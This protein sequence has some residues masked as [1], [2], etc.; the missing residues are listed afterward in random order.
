MEETMPKL[1]ILRAAIPLVLFAFLATLF[2]GHVV[3]AEYG[4]TKTQGEIKSFFTG[5]GSYFEATHE[6]YKDTEGR[7]IYCIQCSAPGPGDGTVTGYT[8]NTAR[9][10]ANPDVVRILRGIA[11]KGYPNQYKTVIVG[12]TAASPQYASGL[13]IRD[14]FLPM[15]QAEAQAATSFAIHSRM[16]ELA[17]AD[18]PGTEGN[19]Y[20]MENVSNASGKDLLSVAMRLKD[21]TACENR[22]DIAWVKKTESGYEETSGIVPSYERD[23]IMRAYARITSFNC[24][25]QSVRLLTGSGYVSGASI[26]DTVYTS[27]FERYVAIDIPMTEANYKLSVALA[28]TAD[29]TV[30]GSARILGHTYYQDM[31]S[32]AR[33]EQMEVRAEGNFAKG[34]AGVYKQDAESKNPI[35]GTSFVVYRNA[36]CTDKAGEMTTDTSG[37]ASLGNL[38]PGVYYVKEISAKAGYITDTAVHR[39]EVRPGTSS[40]FTAS[41]RR[42][43]VTISVTKV[44][45]ETGKA[46]PQGDAE[47]AGAVYGLYADEDIKS[48]DA[49]G[50][51]LFKKD[52][53]V[54]SLT[55][56]DDGTATASGLYPGRYYLKEMKAPKGYLADTEKHIVDCSV[57]SAAVSEVKRAI[58]L[59][60]KPVKAPFALYKF[61]GREGEEQKPLAGAGF[62]A[63]LVSDLTKDADGN[64][65]TEGVRPVALT[66]AGGTEL[67]TD[68]SGYALSRELPYGTYLVRE[69][70][71][72]QGMLSVLDFTVTVDAD[73]RTP[74]RLRMLSDKEVRAR[75]RLYK[76]DS[77]SGERVL[78]P[79][80]GY[81]IF[82]VQQ[83]AY[84]KQQVVYPKRETV[85]VFYTDGEGVLTLPEELPA[86]IYEIEEVE[87]PEDSEYAIAKDR[88]R[89]S[90]TSQTVLPEH[91]GYAYA[92]VR[93]PNDRVYGSIELT[94]TFE[95]GAVYATPTDATMA[96]PLDASV[97]SPTDAATDSFAEF[98]LR[99]ACDIL[100]NGTRLYAEGEKV[101]S[102]KLSKGGT[103]KFEMLPIGRYTLYETKT[104]PGYE[105]MEEP[106]TVEI[107]A[108][109]HKE[110]RPVCRVNVSNQRTRLS[111][112]KVDARN[113]LPI[114]GAE[115]ILTD[116]FGREIDRWTSETGPHEVRGLCSGVT[117]TL[118]ETHAP[119][120][121]LITKKKEFKLSDLGKDATGAYK[122]IMR[123][124]VPVGRITV[125]KKGEVLAEARTRYASGR[126]E[127]MDLR[128]EEQ[129]LA[130]V[131]FALYAGEDLYDGGRVPR[132]RKGEEVAR[133]LTDDGGIACF[134]GLPLG[135]YVLREISSDGEHLAGGYEK[136]IAL[137]YI[138]QYTSVVIAGADVTNERVREDVVVKK[139]DQSGKTVLSGAVFGL[140]AKED[141]RNREGV[142]VIPKDSL[143]EKFV[144]GEDGLGS[145][146]LYL[147]PGAYEVRELTAPQGYRLTAERFDV[148]LSPGES[149]V[150]HLEVKN[151][152]AGV[153]LGARGEKEKAPAVATG[154]AFHLKLI[155]MIALLA[156]TAIVIISVYFYLKAR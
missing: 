47:L 49:K 48:P 85:E 102:G 17:V 31:M 148:P 68:A 33:E 40:G 26:G 119:Y 73:S 145:V 84:V 70:T 62:T 141:I 134:D 101:G 110:A 104:K 44:D 10:S 142:L 139:T 92:E 115:M 36:A 63:W 39:L 69:T 23:G 46:V 88:I 107:T 50:S 97:A 27:A 61:K 125:N 117:Y 37:H 43:P 100:Q 42:V 83:K 7:A 121:Y 129:S 90:V 9:A 120:G 75:L 72:P 54:K 16:R 87:V 34:S 82:D 127:G 91:D 112:Y 53:L 147:L 95:T 57:T 56:G 76:T 126:S 77:E 71:V 135:I 58:R 80:Y 1:H 138:D 15:T 109:N 32:S 137:P 25:V 35:D 60:E 81:R 79:G 5:S 130:D 29:V 156:A 105:R 144:S 124:D 113:N 86:G 55:I 131:T 67:F 108:G 143:I 94:K 103:L 154:D 2:T 11:D 122:I 96:T 140:F 4:V 111:V 51:L 114:E 59:T 123:D 21:G 98:E 133:E 132:Y 149:A 13:I 24:A 136:E 66:A 152:K 89:F 38:V 41:N 28:A 14:S 22:I 52:A 153:V 78:E 18:V 45:A 106:V 128:Y 146:S 12:G 150:Y 6:F 116:S 19:V 155:V 30:F 93:F 74:L 3:A 99:A 151:A 8:E 64:Y 20:E 65:L 118:T